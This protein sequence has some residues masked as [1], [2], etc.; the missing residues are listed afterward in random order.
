ML[1]VPIER[2][3]F[4]SRSKHLFY[5]K[6][7]KLK[8][9]GRVRVFFKPQGELKKIQS[10]IHQRILQYAPS[11]RII[12]SY[13]KQRDS[14]SNATNHIG[15]EYVLKVD[16]KDF[17]PTIKPEMIHATLR[18]L[19]F[20]NNL[21]KLLT[22]ICSFN[23]QL[24]Q[25]A[26][27]SPAIANLIQIPLAKRID[28]LAEI[29]KVNR[30]IFGDDVYL[31]GTKRVKKSENLV[32]RIIEDG[33]FIINE[34]KSGVRT[35]REQ[36]LVTGIVVNEKLNVSKVYRRKLRAIIHNCQTKGVASQF[37][38]IPHEAKLKIKGMVNH[39]KKLNS[40]HGKKLQSQ[41]EMIDW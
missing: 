20:S 13:K 10:L 4:I 40:Q 14:L 6:C 25:G 28:T 32:R 11:H 29:H 12:H 7:E 24:P 21:A 19:G 15:Q 17:F 34:D 36:Q 3:Y 8:S 41:F 22:S 5:K 2:L 31:S 9:D 30:S 27:T 26:P 33:G 16:R 39:V 23:E 38:G 18:K 35:S 37:E 1:E